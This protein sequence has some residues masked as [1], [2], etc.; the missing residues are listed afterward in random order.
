[1]LK[2]ILKSAAIL[3]LYLLGYAHADLDRTLTSDFKTWLNA[4]GY[5][6]WNFHRSD[7][8]GGAYGGKGSA[9]EK[10]THNPIIYFNGN[11]DIAVGTSLGLGNTVLSNL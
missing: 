10:I 3:G 2:N 7:L 1:M 4:N 5:S 11:S 8:T 9:D 6:Q